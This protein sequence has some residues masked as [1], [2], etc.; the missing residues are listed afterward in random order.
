MRKVLV[1]AVMMVLPLLV[2]GCWADKLVLNEETQEA[3]AE[4]DAAA[5]ELKDAKAE[6]EAA[7]TQE[8]KEAATLRLEAALT[9][10]AEALAGLDKA[11]LSKAPSTVEKLL[12]LI[13]GPLGALALAIGGGAFGVY[14]GV[15]AKRGD[16]AVGEFADALEEVGDTEEGK[17]VKK[18]LKKQFEKKGLTPYINAFLKAAGTLGK[19]A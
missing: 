7:K 6:A 11:L 4:R 10:S 1:L 16:V 17:K 5:K 14:K 15:R 18:R 13:P 3:L 12:G 8:E 9:R 2:V 19:T